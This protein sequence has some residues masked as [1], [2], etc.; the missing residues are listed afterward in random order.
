MSTAST[1]SN[2][3]SMESTFIDTL[4]DWRATATGGLAGC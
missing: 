4:L 1:L 2:D 3:V